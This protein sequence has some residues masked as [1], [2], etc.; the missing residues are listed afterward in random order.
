MSLYFITSNYLHSI[1][2]L[3]KDTILLDSSARLTNIHPNHLIHSEM[4]KNV[5]FPVRQN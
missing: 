1:Y 2:D 3:T 5:F 4:F